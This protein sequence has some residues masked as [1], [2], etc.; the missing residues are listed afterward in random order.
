MHFLCAHP[1]IDRGLHTPLMLQ[2]VLGLTAERIASAFL[3]R[4][5]TMGQRLSRAKAKITQANIKFDLPERSAL[6][7]RLNAVL[8]AVYAAYGTGWDD[9]QG[10]DSKIQGLA[11]EAIFLG[12]LLSDLLPEEP[13]V[14]GITALMLYCESRKDTR[15]SQ[16]GEY[17]PLAEQSVVQWCS[18]L[19]S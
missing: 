2:A 7:R 14:R 1:A 10:S 4:P 19:R 3:V 12:R 8:E 6:P 17:I 16:N 9:P 5:S 11:E 18:G 15:R 13:E